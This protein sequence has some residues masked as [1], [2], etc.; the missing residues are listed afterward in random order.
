MIVEVDL[1]RVTARGTC[2][3]AAENCGSR[4][5]AEDPGRVGVLERDAPRG[6]SRGKTADHRTHVVRSLQVGAPVQQ[7][8]H[9][10]LVAMLCRHDQ[11]RDAILR[12]HEP[13]TTAAV[14]A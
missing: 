7:Y 4:R 1:G 6:Q 13:S 2:V 11:R 5:G 10:V 3:T 9:S 14:T 8:L 12:G